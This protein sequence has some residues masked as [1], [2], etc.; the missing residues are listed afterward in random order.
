MRITFTKPRP[1]RSGTIS[2]DGVRVGTYHIASGGW[3]WA[4]P[5]DALYD[6]SPWYNSWAAGR[7]YGFMSELH[8]EVRAWIRA[9]FAERPDATA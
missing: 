7:V 1:E 5:R 4:I 3:G 6:G 8:A 9:R 2:V